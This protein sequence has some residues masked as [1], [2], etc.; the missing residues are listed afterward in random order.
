MNEIYA[1]VREIEFNGKQEIC[2]AKLWY[3]DDL[4][5]FESEKQA[6]DFM[7]QF[8]V[9]FM[10]YDCEVMI[11]RDLD[12]I[13]DGT[14]YSDII[15]DEDFIYHKENLVPKYSIKNPEG[16]FA[17]FLG[18]VILFEN[19]DQITNFIDSSPEFFTKSD[20]ETLEETPQMAWCYYIDFNALIRSDDEEFNVDEN[21][22][23]S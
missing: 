18:H 12:V 1:I 4:I 3:A 17:S 10:D 9:F 20:Y 15:K 5:L 22:T 8:P 7:E 13:K 14:L 16:Q 6:V 11:L 23:T 21:N 2:Y 19:E